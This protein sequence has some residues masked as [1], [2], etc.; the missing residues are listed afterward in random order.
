MTP[1]LRCSIQR[2]NKPVRVDTYC[3]THATREAD[4]LFSIFIRQRDRKC[5]RCWDD[6][7]KVEEFGLQC[8]HVVSRKYRAT[9]WD[10]DNAIAMDFRCHSWQTN[11]PLEGDAYFDRHFGKGHVAEMRYRALNLPVPDLDIVLFELRKLVAA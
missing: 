2:C 5:M 11:W 8:C 9:R 6:Y 10:P 4:R 3:R 7:A 1:K